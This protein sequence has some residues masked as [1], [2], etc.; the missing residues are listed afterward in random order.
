V[1]F[2]RILK[3]DPRRRSRLHDFEGNRMP[4]SGFV[5]LFPSVVT[6]LL[7]KAGVRSWSPW[8]PYPVVR[9]LGKLVNPTWHVLEFGSGASTLWLADRV[10]NVIS[11]EHNP[12]WYERVRARLKLT[13]RRNVELSLFTSR[14]EYASV[15]KYGDGAFDFVLIDGHWRDACAES[16]VRAVRPGGF[17]YFDNSDVPDADHRL[18][19]A[20]VLRNSTESTRFVGLCP[21]QIGANQ[22]L[23]VR[24]AAQSKMPQISGKSG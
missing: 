9:C 8:L 11:H 20:T 21:G 24:T 15:E 19:V 4:I 5:D 7:H 17:V 1:I 22:G 12:E 18:A 23:L 2:Q 3:G 10:A 16:A 13:G 6:A 14:D